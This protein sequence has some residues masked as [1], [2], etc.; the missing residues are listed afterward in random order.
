MNLSN[1][2][3]LACLSF[4]KNF[5][6][7]YF[8]TFNI[9]KGFFISFFLSLFIF[10]ELLN[11]HVL[12][13]VLAYLGF[14]YF[15]LQDKKVAFWVGFFIGLFWF[16]WISFSFIHY[17]FWYLLPFGILFVC[18]IY[19]IL[20]WLCFAFT[21]NVW[22]KGSLVLLMS[23]Y[24]NPF[25]FNWL[26]FRIMLVNSFFKVD[27]VSIFLFFFS[28]ICFFSCQKYWKLLSIIFLIFAYDYHPLNSKTLPFKVELVNTNIEQEE[29]WNIDLR[30]KF[31]DENIKKIDKA[32]YD[33]KDVII[34]PESAFPT[35][36]NQMPNLINFLKEKSKKITIITGSLTYENEKFYN[37]T[38]LFKKEQ[39]EIFHKV[40]LVPFGEE[41]P[42]PNFMKHWI[43]EIFY[44]GAEDFSTA[45]FPQDYMLN[46][47][48]IRNA[49]CF[50]A[51]KPLLYKNQPKFM[52]A[53]S[54]NAWF[55]PSTE[56]TIQHLL[57]KL[58]SRLNN[59]TIYHS[60]N[61]SKSEIITN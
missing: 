38:Y 12:H 20:F 60:V 33:K 23:L 36:L 28:S 40:I 32:I 22:I 57:L 24:L 54:N 53:I 29:K 5:V 48:L 44:D 8:T 16:Y 17:G 43:N 52:I 3:C 39:M 55:M 51:T 13:E 37:S 31:I 49:I 6:R 7:D 47:I 45:S 27:T 19:G 50:E 4:N 56:P 10:L 9:I 41:I 21:Q 35:Y 1:L 30:D 11:F 58:Y 25:G 34:F 15:I 61:G 18:A 42:F 2:H 26:D 14:G 46:D 59:T